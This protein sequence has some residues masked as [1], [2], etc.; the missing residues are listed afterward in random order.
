M[1]ETATTQSAKQRLN[2]LDIA[3]FIAFAGMVIVNFKIVMVDEVGGSIFDVIPAALEG[4]AAAT[5]VVLAGI[6]LG[7]AAARGLSQ[8][9]TVTIKRALFL[10]VV[11]LLNMLVFDADILHYYA[12]YFFFGVMLLPFRTKAL[13]STIL[14]LNLVFIVMILTLDYDAGWQWE[15][16]IYQDFWTPSGFVR[17]LFFNGWHPV[18]PWLGFLI[19]GV[20][21]SRL[22]LDNKTIQRRL[23]LFGLLLVF[24]AEGISA[25]IE[26]RFLLID[27]ELAELATT[28]PLPPM[29]LYSMAGIGIASI[30]VGL[31]LRFSDFFD[32]VGITAI[33]AP[34]GRQT[35]TL[36]IAH[37]LVGMGTLEALG[38]LGGQTI[39]MAL[40]ASFL[41]CLMASFY[42][43]FWSR[44]FKR[45]PIEA[46][47]RQLA[48]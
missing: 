27:K 32:E 35:L 21:I 11:G 48:G 22:P 23:I 6:G 19:Y 17:N 30:V 29:P 44:S 5:F 7:L 41:F 47:M 40:V 25:V 9:V 2:G 34:A 24:I 16:F 3:R 4:R 15:G 13:I 39:E 14:A 37:I 10:L 43:F 45:G 38:F 18:I 31:C 42:A 12:F 46:L 33:I 28:E 36:Y 26:P 20:I 8:T 1:T